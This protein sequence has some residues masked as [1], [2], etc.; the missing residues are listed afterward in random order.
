MGAVYVNTTLLGLLVRLALAAYIPDEAIAFKTILSAELF[1][2]M[3]PE[4]VQ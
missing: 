1:H 4:E 3:L 2:T